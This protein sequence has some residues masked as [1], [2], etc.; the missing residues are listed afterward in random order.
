MSLALV[1]AAFFQLF[2]LRTPAR[3]TLRIQLSEVTEK[4]VGLPFPFV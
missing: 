2:V 3:H 4:L 1:I